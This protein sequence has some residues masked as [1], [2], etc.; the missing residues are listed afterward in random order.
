MVSSGLVGSFWTMCEHLC[1]T[2]PQT[3]KILTT[4][5][6][7]LLYNAVY[8]LTF[9]IPSN[10]VGSQQEGTTNQIFTGEKKYLKKS[11]N[12]TEHTDPLFLSLFPKKY[13]LQNIY[14]VLSNL[15]IV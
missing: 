4:S 7:L 14:C 1:D 11:H 6:L 5:K 3:W 9:S 8:F 12:C 13:Y 10:L 15:E 2:E